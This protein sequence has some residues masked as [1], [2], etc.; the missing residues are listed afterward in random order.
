MWLASLRKSWSFT[1]V[2]TCAQAAPW[3]LKQP[4]SS[5]FLVS[6]E[7]TGSPRFAKDRRIFSM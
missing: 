1:G 5:F 7:I 2:A 4:M 6:T 3:F